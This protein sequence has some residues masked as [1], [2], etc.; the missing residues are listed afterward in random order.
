METLVLT[1]QQKPTSTSSV[2]DVI[3]RT[4]PEQWLI[5]WFGWVGFYVINH[6]RLFNAKSSLYT[7]NTYVCKDIL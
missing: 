3:K 6:C 5:G 7:L 2:L 1:D 4:Y